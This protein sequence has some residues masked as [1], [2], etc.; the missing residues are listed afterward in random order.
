MEYITGT[1][2]AD[3]ARSG[4]AV[5][6]VGSIYDADN[7]LL[8]GISGPGA[9]WRDGRAGRREIQGIHADNSLLV[10][11]SG[12]GALWRGGRAGRQHL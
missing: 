7:S 1:E 3:R 8:V 10:G 12:P 11:I 2:S 5:A 6:R 4:A 9:L